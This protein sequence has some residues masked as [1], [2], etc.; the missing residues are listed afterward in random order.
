MGQTGTLTK[1]E[2]KRSK[3]GI[4]YVVSAVDNVEYISFGKT[5]ANFDHLT[6][7]Q[8]VDYTSAPPQEGKTTPVIIH[9]KPS[10]AA[11]ATAATE[12]TTTKQAPPPYTPKSTSDYTTSKDN[13]ILWQVAYK[14]AAELAA[15]MKPLDGAAAVATTVALAQDL[16]THMT[17]D[18]SARPVEVTV[19]P[20]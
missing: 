16:H 2:L 7:G 13:A 3:A 5:V 9:I 6:V 10:G 11:A 18:I 15:S 1:K 4:T 20:L 8:K 14:M 19:N 12:E 17:R